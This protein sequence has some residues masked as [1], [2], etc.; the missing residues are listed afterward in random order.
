MSNGYLRT[1][2]FVECENH[3]QF[4][5]SNGCWGGH[6]ETHIVTETLCDDSGGN[7]GSDGGP[8]WTDMGSSTGGGYSTYTSSYPINSYSYTQ[9]EEM[10]DSFISNELNQE[11]QRFIMFNPQIS[12][13]IK[14]YLFANI[15]PQGGYKIEAMTFVKQL[16]DLAITNNS[17][18]TFDSSLNATNSLSF[19]S[20][21]EFQDYL[22]STDG[23][24]ILEIVEMPNQQ[25]NYIGV[26]KFKL[27]SFG[28]V[29]VNI[30]ITNSNGTQSVENV[31]SNDYGLTIFDKWEQK[32]FVVNNVSGL[33][34]INVIGVIKSEY[35]IDSIGFNF[36]QKYSLTLII[37]PI[38]SGIQSSNWKKI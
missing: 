36:N 12:D 23:S 13:S 20:V 3:H 35:N 28:G 29:E 18:F 10:F 6:W 26:Y 16:I 33:I 21:E 14:D 31:T 27:R 8:I 32:E 34:K 4:Q 11:Q 24:Q 15:D 2:V 37:D 7:G 25:N 22:T 9:L 17:T 30:K 19:N 1:R 5:A 38:T